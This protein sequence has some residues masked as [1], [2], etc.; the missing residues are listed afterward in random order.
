MQILRETPGSDQAEV[1]EM[2]RRSTAACEETR[3]GQVFAG[4]EG[5]ARKARQR[6][7]HTRAVEERK[8][9]MTGHR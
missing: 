1:M 6:S 8:N 4:E 2:L 7:N 3:D 5:L 9:V